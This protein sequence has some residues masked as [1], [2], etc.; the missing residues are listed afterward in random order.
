VYDVTDRSTFDNV[1]QWL[2][3]IDRYAAQTVTKLLVGNKADL[4]DKRVVTAQEA[5]EFA[6]LLGKFFITKVSYSLKGISFLETSAKLAQNVDQAFITMTQQIKKR[7]QPAA[8]T[9]DTINP[10]QSKN[11]QSTQGPCCKN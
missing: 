9:I 10:S 1:K 2:G 4:N 6:D 8:K 5:K 3:E 7:V 11:K